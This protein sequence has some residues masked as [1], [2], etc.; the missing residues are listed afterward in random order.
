MND[1]KDFDNILCRR[2]RM[3]PCQRRIDT[4]EDEINTGDEYE[5]ED[6]D[7]FASPN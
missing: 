6:E 7:A 1:A 3:S 4:S 5:E 2:I